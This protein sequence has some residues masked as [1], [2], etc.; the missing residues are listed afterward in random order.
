[1][2]K[3]SSKSNNDDKITHSEQERNHPLK[4]PP[5]EP[6][7]LEDN[8]QSIWS[9]L[10]RMD[11]DFWL[12]HHP[13]CEKFKEHTFTAF[14]RRLCIGCFIGYPATILGLVFATKLIKISEDYSKLI[15]GLGIGL[16]L[17]FLLSFTSLTEIK[18]VKM[19]QKFLMGFGSGCL[20]T[21]LFYYPGIPAALRWAMVLFTAFN[22]NF[23]M[24][25][26]HYRS[27]NK[28]CDDCE[29][30]PHEEGCSGYN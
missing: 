5:S 22:L 27:H 19:T 15:F 23:I 8:D 7:A 17:T 9:K 13:R 10:K 18:S 16:I 12:S 28:V 26:I 14:G 29:A 24:N 6:L 11:K 1:M 4:N 25:V 20:L 3:L 21:Y 30:E 2:F